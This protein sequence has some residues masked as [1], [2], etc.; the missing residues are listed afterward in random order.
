[1]KAP[2][3]ET[4]TFLSRL[5]SRRVDFQFLTY[6]KNPDCIPGLRVIAPEPEPVE[7]P[8][9]FDYDIARIA[10]YKQMTRICDR[11][12]RDFYLAKNNGPKLTN[13]LKS[14]TDDI[15]G[16]YDPC[17]GIYLYGTYSRG[18]SWIMQQII[19]MMQ[20]AHWSGRYKRVPKIKT[21]RY[22]TDITLR[23]RQEGNIGFINDLKGSIYLDDLGYESD[24]EKKAINLY[25]NKEMLVPELITKLHLLHLDGHKIYISSNLQPSEIY[26]TYGDK[27][28]DRLKEM[29]TPVW[30]EGDYNLRTNKTEK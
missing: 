6:E 26:H 21:M 23:A 24:E 27:I 15:T 1:M 12:G 5:R 29:C 17:K 19:L 2:D 22:T 7:E 18:K 28:G 13:I 14:I 11:E 25:G 8:E 10:L 30:W 20:Y 16:D 9:P 3:Q 4:Q